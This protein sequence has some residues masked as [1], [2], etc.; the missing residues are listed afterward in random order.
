MA[1]TSQDLAEIDGVLSEP[2]ADARVL[3][4][5]RQRFPALSL[6]RCDA[7]DVDTEEPFRTYPRFDLYLVDGPAHCWQLTSDPEHA[8]GLLLAQTERRA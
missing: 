1:L 4:D 2:D 3:A 6:T 5:L 7:C 8:T